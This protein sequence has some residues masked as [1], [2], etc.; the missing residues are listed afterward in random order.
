MAYATDDLN[1][2]EILIQKV[3]FDSAAGK[4]LEICHWL[5]SFNAQEAHKVK[6]YQ[7]FGKRPD[8]RFCIDSG[9]DCEGDKIMTNFLVIE[10]NFEIMGLY[11]KNPEKYTYFKRNQKRW[12][13][14][15]KD[16]S[17]LPMSTIREH[18][19]ESYELK[20]KGVSNIARTN[21][22]QRHDKPQDN[23]DLPTKENFETAYRMLTRPGETIS[24]D[25]ILD[26]I[27]KSANGKGHS[28][29]NNWRIITEKNIEI[30]AKNQ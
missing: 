12:R 9:A 22:A 17:E 25:A 28:L 3:I 7:T 11:S 27:E 20:L 2:A 21:N 6:C 23:I 1:E 14:N 10:P 13:I 29:K 5:L 24:I 15:S 26:Q 30:W 16:T 19:L 8:I 18:I 4:T